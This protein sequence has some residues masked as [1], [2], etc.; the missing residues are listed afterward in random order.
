MTGGDRIARWQ[1]FF[2][3]HAPQYMT[4]CFTQ[5]TAAEVQFLAETLALHPGDHVLDVGCGT[6][7]HAVMLAGM[8]CLVTGIDLSNGMLAEARK[9]AVVAGVTV[10]W[11]QADAAEFSLA[12]RF[13]AAICLC[14]GAFGLLG[15]RK[16]AIAQPR[17]I[18]RNISHALKPGGRFVLTALNALRMIRQYQP[19]E[20]EAGTFDPLTL[21][22]CSELAP[23][24]NAAPL[25]TCER[26]F[27]PTELRLLCEEAGLHVEH[28]WG[29]TAGN[30]GR[31]P[32]ELDEIETMVVAQKVGQPK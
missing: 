14:E 11:V 1:E 21:T 12:P 7:R 10:E 25:P 2:D 31:R 15:S 28:V 22:E 27:V 18:L 5:N 16:D 29:G 8:G 23:L 3:A 20:V 6:G 9:A 26:G 24:E 17:A 30:W 32:V 19:E 4:N 13:D